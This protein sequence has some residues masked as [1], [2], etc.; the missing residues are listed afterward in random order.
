[1]SKRIKYSNSKPLFNNTDIEYMKKACLLCDESNCKVRT[2]VICVKNGMVIQKAHNEIFSAEINSREI[3]ERELALHAEA[4]MLADCARKG[5]SLENST[6][7][8]TRYPCLNCA[9]M[10]IKAGVE[11]IFYM[12]DL[13]ATGNEAENLFKEYKTPIIQIKESAV[14]EI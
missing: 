9:R 10:L 1:M 13:F 14:W 2:A 6:L 8:S 4:V 5:I 12:S 11:R 3:P 7:Y